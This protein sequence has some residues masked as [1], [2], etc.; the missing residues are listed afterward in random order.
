MVA[1]DQTTSGRWD[2][3]KKPG[4]FNA[5]LKSQEVV[6]LNP[7]MTGRVSHAD[8]DGKGESCRP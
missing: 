5:S 2:A 1:L 3:N 7:T 8:H 4:D 6:G